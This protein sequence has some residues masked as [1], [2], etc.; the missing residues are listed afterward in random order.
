MPHRDFLPDFVPKMGERPATLVFPGL[1]VRINNVCV[2][3]SSD[4]LPYH[5]PNIYIPVYIPFR[6]FTELTFSNGTQNATPKTEK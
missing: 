6:G 3:M 5:Y 2:P 1:I 4:P